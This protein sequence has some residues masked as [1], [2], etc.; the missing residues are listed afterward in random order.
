MLSQLKI[1]DAAMKF[2]VMYRAVNIIEINW[3]F[4]I[5]SLPI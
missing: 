1:T 3:I 4:A 2:N 5:Y